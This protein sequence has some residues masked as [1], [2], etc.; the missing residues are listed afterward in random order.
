MNQQTRG[1]PGRFFPYAVPDENTRI[2]IAERA[3]AGESIT[4]L[5]AE[6]RVSTRTITRYRDALGGE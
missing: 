4:D 1:I 5:A 6:Y 2:T 3:A